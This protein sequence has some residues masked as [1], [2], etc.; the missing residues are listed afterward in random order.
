MARERERGDGPEASLLSRRNYLRA[1]GGL[2]GAIGLG[3]VGG[4]TATAESDPQVDVA[5]ATVDEEWQSVSLSG[6]YEDPVVLAPTLSYRGP[7]PATVRLRNVT[8]GSFEVA[9]EEWLYLD[10]RHRDETVGWV[11]TDPGKHSVGD[12]ELAVGR[13]RTN[14][15]WEPVSFPASFPSTPVVFS[16]AQTVAGRQPVTVRNR[17][18]SDSGLSVRLQEE[19]AQ[20]PH[21]TEEIGYLAIE[22]GTGTLAGRAFEAGTRADVGHG[23]QRV[24]FDGTYR[25]P[26]FLADVQTYRGWNTCAVRYRNLTESAVEV[27]VEEERSAD[28]E[29]AHLGE[30][31]GYLVVESADRDTTDGTPTDDESASDGDTPL[32][33]LDRSRVERLVHDHI[34]DQR[35]EHG[36][37]TLAFDEDLREIA[38]Y[39]SSDMA[40]ND[41]F[42]HESP[43]GESRSDRYE[44]FDYDCRADAGDGR[45][46]TGGENIAY[47][48]YDTD[49][50]TDWGTVRYTTADELAEG[51]VRGWMNS[52]GH[53]ENI[54]TAAWNNEGIGLHVTS[55]GKVYATQNFC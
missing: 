41:Y 3:V 40:E 55:E 43:S 46:Y 34:N 4:R 19:E 25:Q 38:R 37:D 27:K 12:A 7:Q 9:V 2:A 51:I 50:T 24:E 53:R 33:E 26:V 1:T 5:A 48:Y 39:H 28:R 29:V 6:S 30:R 31:V 47:T 35:A 54:L 15:E 21:L 44:K 45:Y 10:G 49:V 18:V 17:D 11:A 22:P 23:W 16:Q 20:G 8:V 36:L 13:V 14:H 32:S 52:E 42:S